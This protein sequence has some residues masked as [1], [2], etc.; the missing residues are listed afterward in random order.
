MPSIILENDKVLNIPVGSTI[1]GREL[2][3]TT[4]S[5]G[6]YIIEAKG[7]G[8]PHP[9]TDQIFTSLSQARRAADNYRRAHAAALAKEEL[10]NQIV[11]SPTHKEQRRAAALALKNGELSIPEEDN[12]E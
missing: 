12:N 4:N 2:V 1:G 11:N 5:M 3:V 9:I 10:K 6:Y 7:P 8:G